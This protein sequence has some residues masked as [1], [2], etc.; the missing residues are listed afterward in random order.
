MSISRERKEL[1]RRNKKAFFIVF[2][3]LSLGE[4]IKICSGNKL[5]KGSGEKVK[6][7]TE[8]FIFFK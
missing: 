6:N 4:K 1:F 5:S 8:L 7:Q 2:E 3:G